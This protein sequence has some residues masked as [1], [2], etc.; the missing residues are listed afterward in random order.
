MSAMS[1]LVWQRLVA[2]ADIKV[3][4]K[5]TLSICMYILWDMMSHILS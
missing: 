4:V 3:V 1:K 5:P 2:V